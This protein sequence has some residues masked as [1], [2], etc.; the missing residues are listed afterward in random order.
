[1]IAALAL[2]W[3]AGAQGRG[4][5]VFEDPEGH[6]TLTLP[7]GW[8][9]IVNRDGLGRPEVKIV[10][11]VNENGLLRIRRQEL[12]AAD[13]TL[14]FATKDEAQ[15]LRF[16]PGYAKGPIENFS[17]AT[18]GALVSYDYTTSGRPMLGRNYYLR[19]AETTVYILRF[20]GSRNTLG[21]MRNQTDAIARSFKGR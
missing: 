11:G 8:Q 20:T 17:G 21:P 16:L 7:S 12:A 5:E 9:A 19:A 4:G 10:Y 1:M 6:Y 3:E 2:P 15:S 18:A 13:Q 14:D